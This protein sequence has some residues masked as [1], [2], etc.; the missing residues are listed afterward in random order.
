MNNLYSYLRRLTAL[1][2]LLVSA[3]GIAIAQTA[4][5]P[6][7][8]YSSLNGKSGAE[9]KTAIYNLVRNFTRVSSYNDLPKYFVYTD[10]R[11]NSTRWWD[12]YS[13]I[14]LNAPSFSGLNRE[15]SFPKS[16]WGG[17]TTVGAYV[18]LNH[19]YPSE[20]A[21]N[22][23]KS[24]YP[25]GEVDA[26]YSMKFDNG[27]T[28]V[29]YP[30]AG[31]GGGAQYVFEPDDEYKGD[32]ARTYF[33]MVTCYQNLT[34]R[35]TYMVSQNLWP[36]LNA[37]SVKLLLQWH[38]EDPVSE[39][40]TLRNAA[41]YKIQNNRNPFI[42]YPSLVE[43]I[44]GSKQTEPFQEGGTVTGTPELVTP[45]QDM[46]LDF[47]QV[48]LGNTAT[49]QLWF[50]GNNLSSPLAVRV[51]RDDAAMFSIPTS[52]IAANLVNGEDG[53]WLTV[54]YK[55]TELG[56]HTARLLIQDGGLPGSR[57][58]ALRGECLPVPQLSALTAT[59]ATDITA[60]GYTANWNV[61]AGEVIDYY[62]VTRT[63]YKGGDAVTEELEAEQN[64]LAIT[65]FDSSERE[66]YVVQ[67]VRLGYRSPA[68]NVIYVDHSGV[69]DISYQGRPLA[70][71]AFDGG[72]RFICDEDHTAV[73]IYDTTGR[74]VTYLDRISH[75]DTVML[76]AGIYLVITAEQQ[77]PVRAI[78]R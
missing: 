34:W 72:L 75:N 22:T 47:G 42:D 33:Y 8:Y 18:D 11:P 70:V 44:W 66:S 37:W 1:S 41:V 5:I 15:H 46:A 58:I 59:A 24:N 14:P 17:S 67:S 51:Y 73:R 49:A 43:H 6:A 30:A 29:G 57:G 54:S 55:P 40:E 48:A 16:W 60:T 10:V 61:P 31:E 25:L 64:S 56:S 78:V 27:V 7:G 52:T 50:K 20:R 76:P 53:Y 68:S 69:T 12:M 26:R 3:A 32:F 74:M 21:A 65:D 77:R 39:K 19:L 36:T 28:K 2:V 63:R 4:D 38:R 35:Y 45:V 71:Y 9:L 13:D 23:A 62:I